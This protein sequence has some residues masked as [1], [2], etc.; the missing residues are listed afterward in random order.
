MTVLRTGVPTVLP[1]D[2]QTFLDAVGYYGM[3]WLTPLA[4]KF[5]AT[6]VDML[7]LAAGPPPPNQEW[8]AADFA[9]ALF[10]QGVW[11]IRVLQRMSGFVLSYLYAI[12]VVESQTDPV[13]TAP[14]PPTPPTG[15]PD[16]P[17]GPDPVKTVSNVYDIVLD[18]Q[19]TVNFLRYE[20]QPRDYV[21]GATFSVTG[22]GSHAVAVQTGGTSSQLAS[23]LWI[24]VS[25]FP[26]T[27]SRSSGTPAL[28]YDLGDISWGSQGRWSSPIKIM[29]LAQII[30]PTGAH[31]D[32]VAYNLDL[33]VTIGIRP[34]YG[35][36]PMNPPLG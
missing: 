27:T 32:T 3:D 6:A 11:D 16:P 31:I 9:F 2:Y 14:T 35:T 33:G 18:I 25:A 12:D 17:L 23:G 34:L 30:W 1:V 4:W 20:I 22:T 21:F 8:I 28:Y 5:P 29:R 36:Q 10:P 19:N 13:P 15:L 26:A 7:A 24:D